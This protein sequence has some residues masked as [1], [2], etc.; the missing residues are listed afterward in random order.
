ME[1]AGFPEGTT[2][3]G[4]CAQPECIGNRGEN[5]PQ[6]RAANGGGGIEER[7]GAQ[8]LLPSIKPKN[9]KSF[10]LRIRGRNQWN[11][12]GYENA[13]KGKGGGKWDANKYGD[14]KRIENM[15]L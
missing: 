6:T 4:E 9:D 12:Q 11:G 10:P 14:P 2:K 1:K 5:S 3:K 13:T 7:G 8:D 15:P